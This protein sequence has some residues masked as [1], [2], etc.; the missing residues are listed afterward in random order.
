MSLPTKLK[1]RIMIDDQAHT[2]VNIFYK[3]S[4]KMIIYSEHWSSL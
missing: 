3:T 1:S 4:K 2:S